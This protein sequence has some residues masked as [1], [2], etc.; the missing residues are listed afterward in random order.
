MSN[1]NWVMFYVNIIYL[2]SVL[3]AVSSEECLSIIG[4]GTGTVLYTSAD[5]DKQ[6][7]SQEEIALLTTRMILENVFP[8]ISV[9]HMETNADIDDLVDY[10]K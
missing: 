6:C 5:V 8:D 3:Y 9:I 7:W 1:V 2:F 10:F 4:I